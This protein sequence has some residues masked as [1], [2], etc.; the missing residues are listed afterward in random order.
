MTNTTRKTIIIGSGPAGYTA[1]IYTG[2]A[3]LKPL[4]ITGIQPGGQ[5][6]TTNE[7]ENFP[8]YPKGTDGPAMM[9]DLR[10]QAERFGTE[11]IQDSV[12]RVDFNTGL[13]YHSVWT[14]NGQHYDAFTV[15]ISTG[16][17]ANYLGLESEKLLMN[18]GVS[19]CAVCDGFF[20][21]GKVVGVVGGGDTA[22]EEAIYLANLCP[23]VCL[24]VRRDALRASKIMQERVFKKLNIEIYWNTEVLEVVGTKEVSGVRLLKNTT[25]VESEISLNGLFIAIGH[26]PTT[27]LFVDSLELDDQG[28]I[29]I[30]PGSSLTSVEGVFACGDVADKVYRQAITAAGAGCKAALDA[31]RYLNQMS[32]A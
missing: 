17:A 10:A 1:A 16:A 6:I 13:G 12:V 14:E 8:G 24:F 4:L 3:N 20:F 22:C 2:R 5:L 32:L 19:A 15:I 25:K 26:Q 27:E 7:V 31:E 11:V 18:K 9:E 29:V 30:A 21:R 23:T 28:Y